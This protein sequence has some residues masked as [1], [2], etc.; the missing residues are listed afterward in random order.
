MKNIFRFSWL[1]V[2]SLIL[3]SCRAQLQSS[4]ALEWDLMSTAIESYEDRLLQNYGIRM[5]GYQTHVVNGDEYYCA[6]IMLKNKP[7]INQARADALKFVSDYQKWLLQ[8][9]EFQKYCKLKFNK[10]C[11]DVKE[12]PP[13]GANL[14]IMYLDPENSVDYPSPPAIAE[15]FYFNGMLTYSTYKYHPSKDILIPVL[16]ESYQEALDKSKKP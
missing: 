10:Q 14:K 13:L 15:V 6:T 4:N 2:F 16:K 5:S 3:G 11:S 1:C 12:I 7:T 8:N 9:P